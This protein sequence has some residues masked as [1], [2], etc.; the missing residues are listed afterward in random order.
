MDNASKALIIAGSILVALLI[1]TLLVIGWNNLSKVGKEQER[2][3]LEKQTKEFNQQ[4]EAF[5]RNLLYHT[6]IITVVNKAL[7]HNF[8]YPNKITIIIETEKNGNINFVNYNQS[9]K[10]KCELLV[11]L[12]LGTMQEDE[13]IQEREFAYYKCT[14][15]EYSGPDN[16]ISLMRFK[17]VTSDVD[18]SAEE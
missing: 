2:A 17:E 13:Y 12:G 5:N 8:K 14:A 9:S 10:T 18:G 6:D 7:D 3:Q 15:C 16:K 4:Y 1:L 11:M